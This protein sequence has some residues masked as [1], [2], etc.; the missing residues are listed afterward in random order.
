MAARG[1]W[2]VSLSSKNMAHSTLKDFTMATV[3]RALI[4][5]DMRPGEIYS[6]NHLAAQLGIS[7]SPAREGMMALAHKGLFEVVRNRGFRVVELSAHDK[8]EVYDLRLL[9]EVEAVRRSA[10][11]DLSAEQ[12]E[13]VHG[14]AV[15]TVE[16]ADADLVDFLDADQEFHLGLVGLNG[17]ARW[18]DMVETLRDQSR[19][20]GHFDF[21]RDGD[22][23]AAT[24]EEHIAIARAVL[25]SDAELAASLMIEHLE[26]AAPNAH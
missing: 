11:L 13:T 23:L 8:Q 22:C 18:S 1:N 3:R 9:I 6:A 7:Y 21:L 19:I 20:N 24:A 26:Y 2:I 5:G 14:L 16:L 17:N 12:A 15:Q 4:R 10:A 25:D